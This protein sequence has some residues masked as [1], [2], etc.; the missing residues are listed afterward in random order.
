M[1]I[2]VVTMWRRAELFYSGDNVEDGRTDD[3]EYDCGDNVEDG[4]TDDDEYDCG[5]NVED[6]KT[7][8]HEYAW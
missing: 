8:E 7:V 5:D 6:G 2:T 1:N 3:D 4:R